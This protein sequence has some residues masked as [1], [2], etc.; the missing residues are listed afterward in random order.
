MLTT[1]SVVVVSR[2]SSALRSMSCSPTVLT[3]RRRRVTTTG[4]WQRPMRQ[5]RGPASAAVGARTGMRWGVSSPAHT[6]RRASG[7]PMLALRR[8]STSAAEGEVMVSDIWKPRYEYGFNDDEQYVADTEALI[9]TIGDLFREELAELIPLVDRE[10]ANEQRLAREAASPCLYPD[11]AAQRRA[12][13][14]GEA[15]RAR[16]GSG[17]SCRVREYRRRPAGHGGDRSCPN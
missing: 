7:L 5:R 1:N 12:Y 4:A 17:G 6:R 10:V 9:A 3:T 13:A 16:G 2:T 15:P 8:S 14:R 11:R